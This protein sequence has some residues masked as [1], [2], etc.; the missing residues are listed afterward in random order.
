MPP[1]RVLGIEAAVCG[2]ACF[3][4]YQHLRVLPFALESSDMIHACRAMGRWI[5]ITRHTLSFQAIHAV[6]SFL[7]DLGVHVVD[8]AAT[9]S[10]AVMVATL[11]VFV[12]IQYFV[13]V[14]P[15]PDFKASR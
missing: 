8:P 14:V 2:V 12:T 13:M 4:F 10:M 5:F 11:G 6:I 15:H 9:H 3:V 1:P 7:G